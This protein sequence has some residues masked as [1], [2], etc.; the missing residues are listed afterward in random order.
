ME[1]DRK[2]V[3]LIG[4]GGIKVAEAAEFDYSGSQALRA[5]KDSGIKSIVLN[6]NIATVQ[7][8]YAMA[9]SVY[10]LPISS[11]YIK[12]VIEKEKPDAILSGFGGQTALNACLEL[13]N[14]GFLKANN[15]EFL[16]TPPEGIRNALGR[17]DFQRLMRE[18][19]IPVPNS[20]GVKNVE[21][22]VEAAKELGFPVMCRVSFNLGGRGSFIA[23]S[24]DEFKSSISKALAQ[25]GTGEALIEKYLGGWKELEYEVVR[26]CDGNSAIIACLENLDPMGTHTGESVVV[27]PA[28]T[29]DN[30]IYQEMRSMAIRVAESI[31]LIGECNV[32]FALEPNSNR[33]FVIETNPRMSRSSALA[34]KVTGYPIAYIATK[35]ALGNRL[36][37]LRNEISHSTSAYFEPSLD[38][39][40]VKIPR[41]D[42]AKFEMAE[43]SIGSEMKSIGEV[44]GIGRNFEEAIQ[45]AVRMLD[46][47]E[48]GVVSTN[49][50]IKSM[51]KDEAIAALAAKK[52]YWFLYASRAFAENASVAEIC[53]TTGIN[54]F[55]LEKIKHIVDRYSKFCNAE[56]D[57]KNRMI[58][59]M[60]SLGFSEKQ[61][62][63][64]GINQMSKHIDTL[65]G[66]WPSDANYMY[67]TRNAIFDEAEKQEKG[68]S[69]L[70]L[71]AG[72]F[73]IGVSV[74]F[75]YATVIAAEAAK[76]LG[77]S[78]IMLNCNPETVSTDWNFSKI[79]LF[80][81][82]SSESVI[83][84]SKSFG[85]NDVVLFTAGQIGNNISEELHGRGMNILG[86]GHKAIESAEDRK[87][88][89][90]IINELDIKEPEWESVTSVSE[91]ID[92]AMKVGFPLMVR[93]SFVLSGSA[94]GIVNNEEELKR[95]I[96]GIEK[97]YM[98][99]PV[100]I[101]KFISDA[102]E[103]DLDCASDGR[104]IIGVPLFHIEEAGIHS[105]DSTMQ[106]FPT[107]SKEARER[108]RILYKMKQI[109]A[110]LVE[111][112]RIR[113]P[114]NLQFAVKGDVP[115][116]IELNLR[117]SRSMPFS[118]KA[119]GSEILDYAMRGC[120]SHFD[121]EG[122]YVPRLKAYGIKSPQFSWAQIKGAYP[123]LGAEM[124]STGEVA[125]F[126]SN[127]DA[128]LLKSWMSAQPNRMPHNGALIYGNGN[129]T[130]TLAK[131]LA[132]L[133]YLDLYGLEGYESD[134]SDILMSRK[135]AL[136][137]IKNRTIDIVF[138]EGHIPESD[139]WIRRACA[140]F[141]IPIVLNS[142]LGLRLAGAF[143]VKTEAKELKDYW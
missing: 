99:K 83:S 30:Y 124:R 141:N 25:S 137:A 35:L 138:T 85:I 107:E 29:L 93:P 47:G 119:T 126:D 140:D 37:E 26:D 123:Y 6:P 108:E 14:D 20:I 90:R 71:G 46:I 38:Y 49:E 44:M 54:R 131:K 11:E 3:L 120:L 133:S 125:S 19:G 16:G 114:F 84:I 1:N 40:A 102:E 62:G 97:R 113:G 87:S 21:E 28:Q 106:A 101:S 2:K 10:I 105:G 74:E 12:R 13:W 18:L 94:M 104:S 127:I 142:K 36:H 58:K 56:A 4:S 129:S 27:A 82:I 32:Q 53:K 98:H 22:G 7:T 60:L 143:G 91:A 134:A 92:F 132:D 80:D 45:K 50:T 63:Y 76:K 70:V 89:S 122:F 86:S 135:E 23:H 15:V 51:S 77:K 73:R 136:D 41:W 88:F 31:K 95:K 112:L 61:L 110:S 109:A 103:A 69:V 24:M 115:Y 59:E 42:N 117:A 5:L 43:D 96:L 78:V 34:S 8:S 33:F 75:D 118:S 139:Y 48:E 116:V 39:I 81:N 111:R 79:L 55:F 100:V 130:K 67:L 65:A 121:W 17:A 64:G 128:A 68:D 52:P 66:E 72:C 9:D 57:V